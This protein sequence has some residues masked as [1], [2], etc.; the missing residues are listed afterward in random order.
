MIDDAWVKD[1]PEGQQN[2]HY[3]I[4]DKIWEMATDILDAVFTDGECTEED[5][6]AY[7]T[8]YATM[9]QDLEQR[10]KDW[11]SDYV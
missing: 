4:Q 2:V 6:A 9:Q 7:L 1:L 10:L 8:K 3:I 5:V 11:R